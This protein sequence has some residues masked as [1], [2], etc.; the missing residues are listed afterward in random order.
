VTATGSSYADATNTLKVGG[1]GRL[2]IGARYVTEIAGKL[3]TF[4]GR[5]DNVADRDYWASVGG[6]PNAGYLVL[7]NPRTFSLTA[8]VD[9]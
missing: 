4:R 6:Y 2:D 7:G 3:V 1:W 8:S 5:I 9:F